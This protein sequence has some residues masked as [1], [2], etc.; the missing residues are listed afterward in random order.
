MSAVQKFLCKDKKIAKE[1][2]ISL[3]FYQIADLE[4][5]I[6]KAMQAYKDYNTPLVESGVK[7]NRL[8]S[9][10]KET[11]KALLSLLFLE[12]EN[13]RKD[14]DM[15][16]LDYLSKQYDAL[17]ICTNSP[18]ILSML[19]TSIVSKRS[20]RR[21]ISRLMIAG[22]ITK[23]QNTNTCPR[24]IKHADGSITKVVDIN[25]KG[26]G[27]FILWISKDLIAWKYSIGRREA[28]KCGKAENGSKNTVTVPKIQSTE[29]QLFNS[30]KGQ[31]E[32]L[33]HQVF[34]IKTIKSNNNKSGKV[35]FEKVG[36]RP[37]QNF[38]SMS[39]ISDEKM[40]KKNENIA[41]IKSPQQRREMYLTQQE[42]D[43][44]IDCRTPS[45]A[46]D[47]LAMQLWMQIKSQIF[48]K[49]TKYSEDEYFRIDKEARR[50]LKIH[51]YR[52][53]ADSLEDAFD[54]L[55]YSSQKAANYMAR[56]AVKGNPFTPYHPLT[57]LNPDLGYQS[58]L[59]VHF[60]DE[61]IINV[62]FKNLQINK[63]KYQSQ[64]NYAYCVEKS[65]KVFRKFTTDLRDG[66][67]SL[68]R[69]KLLNRHYERE[70]RAYCG[71][72]KV[73]GKKVDTI[74][75]L[76]ADRASAILKE[77]D[78]LGDPKNNAA[79]KAFQAYLRMRK[80]E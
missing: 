58:G 75:S 3:P 35:H 57:Y 67:F 30:K 64:I 51:L 46:D 68:T 17:P 49:F 37:S 38:N 16:Y 65:K 39:P 47:R 53:E 55:S 33:S 25:P 80:N 50:L 40:K 71:R 26:R 8:V 41:V 34:K 79:D 52:L 29:N 12:M 4:F 54:I 60:L 74:L 20:V 44:Q 43:H 77:M 24:Q 48:L 6:K 2:A 11:L 78:K 73:S 14:Q 5:S 31:L 13:K 66:G 59:F 22:F 62:E 72:M 27:N 32:P 21:V 28:P 10:D 61:K 9:S 36:V 56:R 70:I 19:D 45:K 63:L 76:F 15:D 1:R 23:K 7:E 18:Q 42:K 69:K